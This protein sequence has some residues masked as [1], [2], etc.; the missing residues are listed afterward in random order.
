MLLSG[1]GK[2]FALLLSF[3]VVLSLLSVELSVAPVNMPSN[4][5]VAPEVVSVVFHHNPI[6]RPPTYTRRPPK[7]YIFPKMAC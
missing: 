7:T 2:K 6:W 5:S 3:I 1:L 4:P